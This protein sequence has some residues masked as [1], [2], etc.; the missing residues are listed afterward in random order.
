[1]LSN[2]TLLFGLN[3]AQRVTAR[4]TASK[5]HILLTKGHF[6][7]LSTQAIHQNETRHDSSSKIILA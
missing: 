4:A 2:S 3:S 1:M 6:R 5:F 7:H